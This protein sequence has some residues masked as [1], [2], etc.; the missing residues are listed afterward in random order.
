MDLL[1]LILNGKQSVYLQKE[2]M[3]GLSFYAVVVPIQLPLHSFLWEMKKG[4]IFIKNLDNPFGNAEVNT[5][6]MFA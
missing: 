6:F 4:I 5:A 1:N 3:L 2:C